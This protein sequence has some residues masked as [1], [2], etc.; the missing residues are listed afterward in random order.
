M[1][2]ESHCDFICLLLCDWWGRKRVA[3]GAK[4]G[5]PGHSGCDSFYCNRPLD[6][7]W[8]GGKEKPVSRS[9]G[10]DL[11]FW[12]SMAGSWN[13][14]QI[15]LTGS[16]IEFLKKHHSSNRSKEP[17]SKEMSCELNLRWKLILPVRFC[18]YSWENRTECRRSQD[19][20]LNRMQKCQRLERGLLVPQ[21]RTAT[22]R[23]LCRKP[24]CNWQKENRMKNAATSPGS[25]K[26]SLTKLQ[27]RQAIALLR[28][29]V[30]VSYHEPIGPDLA[31]WPHDSCQ[32]GLSWD[33]FQWGPRVWVWRQTALE[34]THVL[35]S[36]SRILRRKKQISDN[37]WSCE[38]N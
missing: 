32:W 20:W 7:L 19:H 15:S 36:I 4:G 27:A 38:Y 37:E 1:S 14:T 29:A 12:W 11:C 31:G 26:N 13:Y 28:E 25:G 9:I 2:R 33:P 16:E 21:V 10:C 30:L 22:V 23:F 8:R 17:S 24:G 34:A 35:S 5:P 3:K 6:S 18:P